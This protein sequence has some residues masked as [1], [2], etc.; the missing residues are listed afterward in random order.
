M[1]H[2][3]TP[4]ITRKSKCTHTYIHIHTHTQRHTH[5]HIRARVPKPANLQDSCSHTHTHTYSLVSQKSGWTVHKLLCPT[6]NP[7][8][9]S[10]S[11]MV[12]SAVEQKASSEQSK[13]L[14]EA[15]RMGQLPSIHLA[16]LCPT[17]LTNLPT[18]LMPVSIELPRH[19]L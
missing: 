18:N 8:R 12:E 2:V 17:T 14:M 1:F 4:A 15:C 16:S 10:S 3:H 9:S 11:S 5:A 7:E 19:I 6:M 13:A